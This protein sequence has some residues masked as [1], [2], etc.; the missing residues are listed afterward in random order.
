MKLIDSAIA[1]QF[2][3]HVCGSGVD[4]IQFFGL[5]GL[6]NHS[7]PMPTF[8]VLPWRF[9]IIGIAV[10][11]ETLFT[12]EET[13]RMRMGKYKLIV[14]A[15]L[16]RAQCDLGLYAWGSFIAAKQLVVGR[17]PA[18]QRTRRVC[19]TRASNPTMSKKR[20]KLD[21]PEPLAPIST[22]ALGISESST[23]ASERK[24]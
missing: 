22:V 5:S 10:E 14:V 21:F 3:N 16:T 6:D 17:H 1:E 7:F 12:E 18:S 23:F 24:P 11:S 2:H 9:R 8:Q 13:V 4:I 19:E 20:M 15:A